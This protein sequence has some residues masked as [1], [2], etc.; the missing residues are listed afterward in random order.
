MTTG[1]FEFC[2]ARVLSMMPATEGC[3]L[4]HAM[5][6]GMALPWRGVCWSQAGKEH[7]DK[8]VQA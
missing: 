1:L 2:S 8:R 4:C 6:A 5:H 3:M 7:T